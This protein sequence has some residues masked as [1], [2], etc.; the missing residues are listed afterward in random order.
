[1]KRT[2]PHNFILIFS[3]TNLV[4]LLWFEGHYLYIYTNEIEPFPFTVCTDQIHR[5]PA[6]YLHRIWHILCNIPTVDGRCGVSL[7]SYGHSYHHSGL[8]HS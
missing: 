2:N 5:R 3:I 1:M 7:D 8:V 6:L 4:K